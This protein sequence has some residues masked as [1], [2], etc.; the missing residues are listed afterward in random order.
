MIRGRDGRRIAAALVVVVCVTAAPAFGAGF[1]IFEHGSE[2][3]GMAGA[4]TA[5]ADDPSAMFHNVGG[6]ALLDEREFAVG[7]TLITQTE[8]EFRGDEPF[9]GSDATAEQEEA[10]FFPSHVYYVQPI[11]ETLVF[12]FSFNT[13]FGLATEWENVDTFPGRF[14]SYNAEL[15]TF[16]LG[17]NIG[18][19]ATPD[20][21]LGFGVIA[22]ASDVVL[23]QRAGIV[24]PFTFQVVDVADVALESDL[25]FG[26][27]FQAGVLHHVNN[28]FSWGFSYRSKVE[29]DYTGDADFTQISTGNPE[30]D[31][32][33]AASLPV[34]QSVGVETSIDFPD[35][36]SLGV[37][38][39]IT[40]STRVE[41]DANW[42]GWS[43]FDTLVVDFADS[44]GVEDLV[45]NEGWD[46]VYNYRIGFSW[47]TGDAEW[48]VGYVYDET[49][50]PSRSMGPLLPD[51]D[52]NGF[53]V[54]YG[55]DGDR[56]SGDL[57]LMYLPFDDRS[58]PDN[59]DGFFGSY[60]TTAWLFGATFGWK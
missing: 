20:F 25:E 8:A 47:A 51:A 40:P 6:L 37:S 26:Y 50:Q 34:G 54:G 55:W 14:I 4:F 38:M 16:D 58:S 3:M 12:G 43:S 39:A 49:P 42:T 31:A 19:R 45:R 2:A 7:T 10:I 28:S 9:P 18:W 24:N 33:V 53:T 5:Q 23:K 15:Q 27:G 32:I 48:R 11:N 44:S 41:V 21:G 35:M 13:P 29:I 36:A 56:L 17:G 60:E 52:R 59:D 57:A 22:R 1:G 30:L 46:D